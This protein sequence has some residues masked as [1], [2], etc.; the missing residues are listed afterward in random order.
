MRILWFLGL[1]ACSQK[2]EPVGDGPNGDT[3]ETSTEETEDT[4][5]ETNETEDSADDTGV[6]EWGV[7][8]DA[9]YTPE[10]PG[11][12]ECFVQILQCGDEVTGTTEG[13]T[14]LLGDDN[15]QQ[16]AY[17]TWQCYEFPANDTSYEGAERIYQLVDVDTL[18]EATITLSYCDGY[19]E[20]DGRLTLF[21][22]RNAPDCDALSADNVGIGTCEG[23]EDDSPAE[24]T[25]T[26]NAT[27]WAVIVEA[28]D[29]QHTNYKLR[30]DC[31]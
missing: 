29:G 27:P 8:C 13:G 20:E 6:N 17:N 18:Q 19:D 12:G 10:P 14:T 11:E 26:G 28:R 25:I 22:A 24:V 5:E 9:D 1:V 2:L 31:D 16:D 7:D 15:P 3:N 4:N 21:A 30:V 23:D